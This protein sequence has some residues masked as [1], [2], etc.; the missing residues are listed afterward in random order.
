MKSYAVAAAC[1]GQIKSMAM[2]SRPGALSCMLSWVVLTPRQSSALRACPHPAP[3]CLLYL[4]LFLSPLPPFFNDTNVSKNNWPPLSPQSVRHR[5]EELTQFRSLGFQTANKTAVTR[6]PL[7][8]CNAFQTHRKEAVRVSLGLEWCGTVTAACSPPVS[9][10]QRLPHSHG[11]IMC[12]CF[13][14]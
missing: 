12:V 8:G 5:E 2:L 11:C 1:W 7:A 6:A 4:S 3:P 14:L 9:Q 13:L 10:G